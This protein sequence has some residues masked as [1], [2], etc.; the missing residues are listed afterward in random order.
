MSLILFTRRVYYATMLG[1]ANAQTPLHDLRKTG[2]MC[3]E[4]FCPRTPKPG[5]RRC[6]RHLDKAAA[7]A[8][9]R[10]ARNTRTRIEKEG[11]HVRKGH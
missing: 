3:I 6:Q 2:A 1:M 4:A 7:K 5:K 9:E 10:R 8:R 11:E